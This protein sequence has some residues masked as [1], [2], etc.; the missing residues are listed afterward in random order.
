MTDRRSTS[1]PREMLGVLFTL[2]LSLVPIAISGCPASPPPASITAHSDGGKPPKTDTPTPVLPPSLVHVERALSKVALP[3][4]AAPPEPLHEPRVMMSHGHQ[5]TCL[6]G[7]GDALP[8]PALSDLDGN[9]RSLKELYGEKLTV[10][11]FWNDR[12]LFA[13][14]QFTRLGLDT[15]HFQTY[16]VNVVAIDV[17]DAPE[18]V[19]QLR[20]QYPGAYQCL[21]DERGE[22]LA[23]VAADKLPRTYLLDAEGRIVWFDIE[24]SRATERELRNAVYWHLLPEGQRYLPAPGQLPVSTPGASA[25]GSLSG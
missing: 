14:E 10:V 12:K 20:G 17:G 18:T 15:D 2:L 5:Q 8:A 7:V 23:R 24:F 19:G 21:V 1:T 22:A 11:V 25:A 6:V 4:P 9:L 13:R 3:I 16:G